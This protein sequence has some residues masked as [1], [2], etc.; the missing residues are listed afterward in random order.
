[1]WIS[2]QPNNQLIVHGSIA[3]R[4]FQLTVNRQ[5]ITGL[6]QEAIGSEAILQNGL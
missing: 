6:F 3:C 4:E 5:S 2:V 1:M